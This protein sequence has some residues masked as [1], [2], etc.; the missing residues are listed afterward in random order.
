MESEFSIQHVAQLTG[1]SIDTLRYYERIGLLEGVRRAPSGHR[2]Y[3]QK[4]L[5][6]IGLLIN[7]RETGMPLAQMRHL[8]QLR[9]QGDAT[10][11][12]RLL[13]LEQHQRSLEQQMQK[14][15]THQLA[16]Q[17]K[18][19]Q[20]KAFLAQRDATW[21]VV[22]VP[23]EQEAEDEALDPASR[24]RREEI[25]KK[26]NFMPN[27]T[28]T[29]LITTNDLELTV[30]EEAGSSTMRA[31]MARPAASGSYPGVIVG[32]ELFGLTRYIRRVVERIARLGYVVI[33][34]DFYH[35]TAPGIELEATADGRARGFALLHQL[36]RQHALN[37]IR[38]TMTYLREREQCSKIGMVGLSVGGHIAYLAATQFDLKA[39][40][41]FY[42]GWLTVQ[43]IPLSQPSP[44]LTLTSGIAQH[45]GYLLFLVGEQDHLIP[46]E[47]RAAIARELQ[48]ARVRHE[49]VTYPDAAHGFFCDERDSFH[50]ASADDAWRRMQALFAMEFAA[51]VPTGG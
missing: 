8:A 28:E 44:T 27:D 5:E 10:A 21:H 48:A 36:T 30:D 11:D 25:K 12:E 45:D 50:A 38:A 42:P 14:L 46:G 37:D 47:Q 51:G 23:E 41:V 9:R 17:R 24:G 13:I 26:G 1:L 7:L 3:R 39:T 22:H 31:Y 34:P 33:A 6:W 16:L 20:K 2:R 19:A 18:I 40:V 35:R 49:I 29:H 15:Q 43:D 32:F 4:D